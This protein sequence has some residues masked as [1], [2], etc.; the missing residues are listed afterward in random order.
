MD[1][2][3]KVVLVTGAASGLGKATCCFLAKAGMRVALL[4]REP[5]ILD[6]IAAPIQGLVISADVSDPNAVSAAL[7]T[8]VQQWGAIHV[9]VNCAGI[10]SAGR[11]VTQQNEPVGLDDFAQVI[12][13]NLLGTFNVMRLLAA[14]MAKQD[15][16]NGDGERGVIINTASIAAFDGQAGQC[17]YSASKGGVAAMTLPAARDLA[18]CG[19]RVMCIAPGVMET[20]MVTALQEK[21]QAG[22]KAGVVF[23]KRMGHADEFAQ[24]V[25]QVI[26]NAYLN[27]TI[28]RLDGGLRM[29]VK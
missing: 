4:D 16:V 8:V 22:L 5:K 6:S 9:G 21:T 12:K 24:L 23:P 29:A 1:I 11:L 17:A 20:P 7:Q 28:V 27:G 3:Q 2:K 10:V 19:I 14:V 15:A 26:E 18:P 25:K 13:V